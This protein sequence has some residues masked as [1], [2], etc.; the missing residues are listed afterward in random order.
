[1]LEIKNRDILKFLDGT[2]SKKGREAMRTWAYESV[3]NAQDLAF[4]QKIYKES[5]KLSEYNPVD[6]ES[7]WSMFLDKTNEISNSDKSYPEIVNDVEIVDAIVA[8]DEDI[9]AYIDGSISRKDK[10]RLELWSNSS[11]DNKEILELNNTILAEASQ[12]GS[13]RS[14]DVD[15]EWTSFMKNVRD[16]ESKDNVI[17]MTPA[18]VASTDYINDQEEQK[19]STIIPMWMRIAA[20]AA[21]ALLLGVFFFNSVGNNFFGSSSEDIY[22]S[23]QTEFDDTH[24]F[25]MADGSFISME[26]NTSLRYPKSVDGL[27]E[28]KLFV[29]GQAQFD[30]AKDEDKPFVVQV[31]DEIGVVVI[32]TIFKVFAH[33]DFVEAVE[34]IEGKVRAYSIKNP[35]IYVDLGPG[36]KYG[37]DGE[38]FV[39]LNA[40]K[41]IDN[42]VEYNILYV[43]DYL[44]AN[45]S[46]KVISSS[47]MPFDEEGMVMIDLEKPLEDILEDLRERAD[48]DYIQLDCDNCYRIIRFKELIQ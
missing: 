19:S 15:A 38:K 35:D 26:E 1:M 9:L 3:E 48:F 40:P 33:E 47:N 44:M 34:N 29:D 43:L 24:E 28:R 25:E 45:S 41:E 23:I 27:K 14:V 21:V 7:E 12:M 30:V 10:N 5:N 31:S 8:T 42:S 36:D 4:T 22:A 32:G 13:Y 46:W 11:P 18:V 2:S 39:D 20:A 6:V 16:G 17:T 37:W